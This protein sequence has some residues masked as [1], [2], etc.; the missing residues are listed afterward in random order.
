MGVA[1]DQPQLASMERA[2]ALVRGGRTQ[3]RLLSGFLSL[4][5]P[6]TANFY[7][8]AIQDSRAPNWIWRFDC[9]ADAQVLAGTVCL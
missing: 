5:A 9:M 8:G 3:Y 1:S 2:A 4:A 6:R 7:A